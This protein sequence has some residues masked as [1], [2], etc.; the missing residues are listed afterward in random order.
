MQRVAGMASSGQVQSTTLENRTSSK[1]ISKGGK[2]TSQMK[3]IREA[4][5]WGTGK[6]P[7]RQ[8][9]NETCGSFPHPKPK[10]CLHHAFTGSVARVQAPLGGITGAIRR[11]HFAIDDANAYFE[12][13][14]E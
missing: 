11:Y 10:T 13:R 4:T 5:L 1:K 12:Q 2:N 7:Y 14:K 9:P 6:R 3:T 8:I